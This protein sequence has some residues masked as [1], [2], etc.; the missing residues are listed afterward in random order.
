MLAGLKEGQTEMDGIPSVENFD[1]I[2]PFEVAG[3]LFEV[4]F[5]TAPPLF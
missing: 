5:T 1:L 4:S 2:L 3:K